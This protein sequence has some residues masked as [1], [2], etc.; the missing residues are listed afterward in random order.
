MLKT[1]KI[2]KENISRSVGMG[3]I[4]AT[5]LADYLVKKGE[6]FRSA[7]EIVARLVNYAEEKRKSFD[8]LKLN[9]YKQFS[10]LFD[11]DVTDISI[12]SSL[13]ARDIP[14]GTAPAQVT[15]ALAAARKSIT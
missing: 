13:A 12:K 3:Y 8:Q 7:H 9:D 2:K 11:K 15:K 5:D 14:G 1:I 4:L 6:P 10:S